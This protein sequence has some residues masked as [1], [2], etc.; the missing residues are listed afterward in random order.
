[1]I[2]SCTSPP[3][4]GSLILRVIQ[5]GTVQFPSR[6]PECLQLQVSFPIILP[7]QPSASFWGGLII[8]PRL[9]IMRFRPFSLFQSWLALILIYEH[10]NAST[11]SGA[12]SGASSS[13]PSTTMPLDFVGN[14]LGPDQSGLLAFLFHH[15]VH[16][17]YVRP[18]RS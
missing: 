15:L 12:M 7:Y 1:M 17:P 9:V 10:A 16:A 3:C 14:Y 13:S 5:L 2:L 4:H 6:A 11:S 8:L 18:P